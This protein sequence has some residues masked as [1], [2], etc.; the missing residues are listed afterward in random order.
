M[1]Y[2]KIIEPRSSDVTGQPLEII[3]EAIR[4]DW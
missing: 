3:R 2:T 1:T 4:L